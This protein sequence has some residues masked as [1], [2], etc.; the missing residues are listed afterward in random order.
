MA[1]T[2][3]EVIVGGI[4]IACLTRH[5]LAALM[6]EECH[7][8]RRTPG[9]PP[10]LVDAAN[11]NAIARAAVDADFRNHFQA[12]DIIHADGLP[13]VLA[14]RLLTKAPIPERSA[15]TDYFLDAAAAAEANGFSFFLLGGSE[16]VNARC[17]EILRQR[18]PGLR[19][20]GRRHGYFAHEEEAAVCEEIN[21][22][23]ADVVWVGLGVPLE[24]SFCARNKARL[25]AG[26]LV[27]CGG[28]FN[29]VT[30]DYP[31]APLWMQQTGLEWLFR[32]LHEPRRLFWRYAVTNPQAIFLMLTRTVSQPV[33]T[34]A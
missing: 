6:V 14:S 24:Q 12:A 9:R 30:G 1:R 2:Y 17:A 7:A 5:D 15:T 11:G 8:A 20:A 13:V 25:R 32:L 29:Y 31:R 22:S 28:C 26:W 34:A 4:K 27:T 19:I 21:A 23:G 3:K 10:R 18:Y 33:V 16:S